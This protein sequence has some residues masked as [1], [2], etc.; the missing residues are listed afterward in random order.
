MAT[1][2]IEREDD[3]FVITDEETGVTTQGE[4]KFEALLMLADAL[5]GYTDTDEDPLATALDIFVPDPDAEEF[6]AD[7]RDEECES[8]EIPE[9]QV[10]R[11]REASLWLPKS[12]KKTDFSD[13]N[14][15]EALL[16]RL[17][18]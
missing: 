15:V 16:E 2:T 17:E 1:I 4:T 13:P 11:Q 9:E 5:A 14:Q 6:A 18:A 7:L 10:A 8:P 3:W 12:H